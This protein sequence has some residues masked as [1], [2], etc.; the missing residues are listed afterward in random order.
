MVTKSAP[1]KAQQIRVELAKL[2][3][4]GE[5]LSQKKVIDAL[6]ERGVVV[7]SGHVSMVA[8]HFKRFK[9]SAHQVAAQKK[10]GDICRK[11]GDTP[12]P[13]CDELRAAAEFAKRCG[14]VPQ[15]QLLLKEL[16]TLIDPFLST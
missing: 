13:S 14:G 4:S 16:S 11:L 7:S 10:N 12:R 1:T 9:R 3:A 5:P 15:A 8:R 6:A 2:Q